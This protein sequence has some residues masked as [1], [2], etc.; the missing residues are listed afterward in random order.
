MVQ[1]GTLLNSC[2]VQL[3]YQENHELFGVTNFGL[4]LGVCI[5]HVVI[6]IN[7]YLVNFF[8]ISFCELL[9]IIKMIILIMLTK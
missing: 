2:I 6:F 5:V 4:V 9:K 8:R 3:D 7:K 1:G